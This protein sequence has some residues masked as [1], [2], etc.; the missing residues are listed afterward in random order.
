MQLLYPSKVYSENMQSEVCM[1]GLLSVTTGLAA[2]STVSI[3][4][5]TMIMNN[6][7]VL[8][9]D[10]LVFFKIKIV[11]INMDKKYIIKKEYITS[12]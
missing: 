3:R 9:K 7:A 1:V 6:P 10:R 11:D 8:L 4:N 2:N 5:P 12:R